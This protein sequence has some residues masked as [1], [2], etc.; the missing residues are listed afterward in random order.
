MVQGGT[1]RRGAK[2]CGTCELFRKADSL[3]GIEKA[4]VV[5]QGEGLS[6][7]G[8]VRW[9]AIR[10]FHA[11]HRPGRAR[12]T[13]GYQPVTIASSNRLA[14][15]TDAGGVRTVSYDARGN[16]VAEN[17]ADGTLVAASYDGHA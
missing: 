17:R 15:V 2:I 8:G 6:H 5:L 9:Q 13:N 14:S 4:A 7:R 16:T 11:R 1:L 10:Q 3:C 12:Q